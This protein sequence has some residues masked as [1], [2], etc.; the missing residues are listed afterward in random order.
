MGR[1]PHM[2]VTNLTQVL[3]GKIC[4]GGQHLDHNILHPSLD[5]LEHLPQTAAVPQTQRFFCPVYNLPP[6]TYSSCFLK[7]VTSFACCKSCQ[8]YCHFPETSGGFCM[9]TDTRHAASCSLASG[10]GRPVDAQQQTL[11]G[12]AVVVIPQPMDANSAVQYR[13]AVLSQSHA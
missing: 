2:N 13:H 8:Y 4:T 5:R 6:T 9:Y 1:Q 10:N 3:P 11:P 12:T 7:S